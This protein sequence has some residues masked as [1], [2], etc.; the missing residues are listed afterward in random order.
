MDPHTT[1]EMIIQYP[2]HLSHPQIVSFTSKGTEV[3]P[4]VMLIGL[5]EEREW[6]D[7]RLKMNLK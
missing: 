7:G 1:Q 3:T 4:E 5:G 6:W 2:S